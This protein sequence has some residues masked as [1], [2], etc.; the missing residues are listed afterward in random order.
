MSSAHSRVVV[1]RIDAEADDLDVAL[2]ELG[3]DLGH[4]AEFGRAD[5]REVLRVREEHAPGIADPVVEA[6]APF[7]GLGLE[8]RRDVADLECHENLLRKPAPSPN[9]K[10]IPE[11]RCDE[12]TDDDG[13]L[14]SSQSV[15]PTWSLDKPSPS[16]TATVRRW[17]VTESRGSG[18]CNQPSGP[19]SVLGFGAQLWAPKHGQGRFMREPRSST[20]PT[21]MAPTATAG[22]LHSGQPGD[23]RGPGLGEEPTLVEPNPCVP[24]FDL[25]ERCVGHGDGLFGCVR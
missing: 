13:Q 11:K 5:R 7:R 2:V 6:D 12:I 18:P 25:H 23:L 20:W 22:W 19:A 1:D 8:I 10:Y 24:L 17:V 16:I 15:V 14:E 21:T 9:G 3:L 4:V